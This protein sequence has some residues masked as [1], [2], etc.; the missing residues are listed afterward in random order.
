[1]PRPRDFALDDAL[2]AAVELFWRQGYAATSVRQLCE[3]MGIQ[4]GSFYA[5]FESKDACFRRALQRYVEV[6]LPALPPGPPAIRAWL[7]AITAPG[8][9]GKGCLLVNSAV[10]S[11]G[12]DELTQTEVAGRLRVLESFFTACLHGRPSARDDAELLAATVVSIHVLAR[13]G[14]RP[15]KL[16]R[17]AARAL[18]LT[19]LSEPDSEPEPASQRAPEP[20]STTDVC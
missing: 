15:A 1:M 9:R 10:E 18:A 11:P 13:S 17:I 12:L 14:A 7:C 2:D 19:G 20:S 4:A 8:R 3:A 16:R 5:A 6:Q